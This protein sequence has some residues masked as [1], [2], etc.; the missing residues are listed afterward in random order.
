M[1]PQGRAGRLIVAKPCG[2]WQAVDAKNI[3][4]VRCLFAGLDSPVLGVS[5][6]SNERDSSKEGD[7]VNT[8]ASVSP[9]PWD[10]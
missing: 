7:V 9:S 6:H 4:N 10:L 1:G 2:W 8:V 3:C 5:A